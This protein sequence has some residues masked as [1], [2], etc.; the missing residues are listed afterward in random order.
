MVCAKRT[1]QELVIS[2]ALAAPNDR[3]GINSTRPLL[4]GSQRT[5]VEI[6]VTR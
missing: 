6:T 4:P 1:G 5:L 2:Q 3:Q